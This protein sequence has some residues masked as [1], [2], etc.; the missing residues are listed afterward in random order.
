MLNS[1]Q[2]LLRK[3]HSLT[4]P[5]LRDPL[6]YCGDGNLHG[7]KAT[8]VLG[9]SASL[10]CARTC[11]PPRPRQRPESTLQAS[12]TC[13]A[14]CLHQNSHCPS[15]IWCCLVAH[16]D[17]GKELPATSP[18]STSSYLTPLD[19]KVLVIFCSNQATP[20]LSNLPQLPTAHW[21]QAS[22]QTDFV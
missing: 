10:H 9:A 4:G 19:I 22:V 18:A 13:R 11:Q 1:R 20:L 21:P 17:Y 15:L 2:D 14:S 8:N 7:V 16:L 5:V 6:A 3:K 12:A